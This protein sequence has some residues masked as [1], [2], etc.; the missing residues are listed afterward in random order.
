MEPHL[1]YRHTLILGSQSPRRREILSSAGFKFQ[2]R[3]Q[4]GID[5]SYCSS[6]E[7]TAVAKYLAEKKFEAQ[8]HL[9]AGSE[10]MICADTV[11]IHDG[12]F[13]G[14]PASK[15]EAAEMLAA[16]S[17]STHQVVTGVCIGSLDKQVAFDDMSEVVF[18]ALS[19][20]EIEYYIKKCNPLDKAGAYGVQDWMGCIGVESIKGSF[21]TVKGLPIHLVYRELCSF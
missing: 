18:G 4:P 3:C 1:A 11:V 8:K 15:E 13:V 20:A 17:G 12:K 21:Y 5:E 2:L 6:M 16:L 19:P 9:L 7:L 10:M 14:K